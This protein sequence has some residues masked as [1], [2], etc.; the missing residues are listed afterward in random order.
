MKK[1]RKTLFVAGLIC[2]ATLQPLT[3]HAVTCNDDEKLTR[4]KGKIFNNAIRPGT[5]LGM[6]RIKIDG[7]K[8][9]C[10]IMGQG[11]IGSDG[12]INFV[13]TLVCNDKV[14]FPQT[15]DIIHSQITLNTTGF[16]NFQA[17]PNGFPPGSAVGTFEET[18][19]PIPGTGRGVFT[20]VER[21]E[22]HI[23]GTINCL[24]AIDMK[25]SGS[26]CMKNNGNNDDEDHH[27]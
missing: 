27:H 11:A 23:H 5:T 7:K 2:A 14:I 21:G 6:A 17:C 12:S 1:T 3:A 18:S 22:I 25:L 19:T 26:I 8:M 9:R 20:N 24:A 10:G 16:A 13:H 15:G 4:V